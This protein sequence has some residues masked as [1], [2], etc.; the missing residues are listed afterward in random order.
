ATALRRA[1]CTLPDGWIRGIGYH[2]SVA[3][4]LHRTLLDAIVDDRPVRVQHRSGQLWVF[5]TA[6]A[7][8]IGLADGRGQLLH[9]D[10]LL[11]PREPEEDM[12]DLGPV[13][14]QLASYGITG[15]SDATETN[16]PGEAAY[17][18][19]GTVQR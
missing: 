3:G 9:G 19:Q 8:R 6:G 16:G 14:R 18:R 2:E 12:P 15:V 7:E 5:N 1:A 10:R 17:L 4:P 11:R 13:C